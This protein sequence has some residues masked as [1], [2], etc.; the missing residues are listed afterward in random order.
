MSHRAI[1]R[2]RRERES[3]ILPSIASDDDSVEEDDENRQVNKSSVFAAAIFHE[4]SDSDSDDDADGDSN[5]DSD[6]AYSC[7]TDNGVDH[8]SS[9]RNNHNDKTL[10]A[11]TDKDEETT[12]DNLDKKGRLSDVEDLDAILEEYKLQDEE[13]EQSIGTSDSDIAPMQ[14]SVITSKMDIR[15]LDIEYVR[16]ALFGGIGVG[17]GEFGSS[18]R[19]MNKHHHIF[20][21]PGASCPRPPH[22]VGGGIGFKTY[23]EK[24]CFSKLL[25][26]PYCDVKEGE[27]CSPPPQNWCEFIHSDSYKRDYEDMQTIKNS[28][29]PNAMLLFIA[30]HPYVVEALLQMSIVMYQMD[31]KNEGLSFLKRALWIFECAA[32]KSFLKLKNRCAVMDYRKEGNKAFL[33]TLFW[34]IRVSYIGGLSRTALAASQLLISLDPLRDTKNVL[35]SIDHFAH[36]CNSESSMLW[37][38]DFVESKEVREILVDFE[39]ALSFLVK[40]YD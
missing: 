16:R 1:E 9:S 32:P 19:R 23:T 2:L 5:D 38:V 13:R 6:S 4:D 30:H 26:W 7:N 17:D 8:D 10:H 15:D 33:S 40:Q 18:S 28:G 21:T 20:G 37:L 29:D 22:Y 31:Q 14:Y 11:K 36:M 3:Q 34:L 27:L 35:L 39:F 24:E 12:S 25:P